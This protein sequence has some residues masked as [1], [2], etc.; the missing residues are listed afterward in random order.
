M[1]LEFLWYVTEALLL[2]LKMKWAG[3][4]FLCEKTPLHPHCRRV[5]PLRE[6]LLV[7]QTFNPPCTPSPN[8]PS[9][10]LYT[11]PPPRPT[12][13]STCCL[14]CAAALLRVQRSFCLGGEVTRPCLKSRVPLTSSLGH[15]HR[16]HM[17]GCSLGRQ[18]NESTATSSFSRSALFIFLLFFL[19]RSEV[20]YRP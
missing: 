20:F 19:L 1:G 7:L 12:Q 11:P 6:L 13:N 3:P 17:K 15:Q 4:S 14:S 8:P 18:Q 10:H 5:T 16:G 9:I 2:R